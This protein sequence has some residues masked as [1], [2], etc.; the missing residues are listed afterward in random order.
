MTKTPYRD[1][2][3]DSIAEIA[4]CLRDI[5]E[6]R[7][8]D[9]SE[10]TALT[11]NIDITTNIATNTTNIATNA[12][13]IATNTANIANIASVP[14]GTILSCAGS[15]APSGYFVCDGTAKSRTTY[16]DLFAQIGTAW[17]AGDGTTTFHLPDFRGA[18]LRGWDNGRGLD[19]SR[20]FG[21]YQA[22]ALQNITGRF[23]STKSHLQGGQGALAI[24]SG[25]RTTNTASHISGNYP[26]QVNFDASRVVRTSVETRPKNYAILY[27][28]KY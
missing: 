14:V 3:S 24:S 21:S 12:A 19:P 4:E 10:F 18:F 15:N 25:T 17:G 22:D 2:K 11:S 20:A 7:R 13:N 26:N 27:I 23:I 9:V 1:L 5:I 6:K 8:E 16:A 28:I